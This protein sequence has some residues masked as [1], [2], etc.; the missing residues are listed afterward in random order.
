MTPRL[1]T[2]PL[3]EL[4]P[5]TSYGFDVID[6]ARDVLETPLDPW[7]EWVAVHVGELLPDGRPRFR[8]ALILVARQNGKTLLAKTLALYWMFVDQVPLVLGTSTNRD[9]ARAVWR[10][11]CDVAT[12]NPML[13][14]EL[15]PKPIWSQTGSEELI[16]GAGA[17]YKFAA[18][19]RRAGRSLT[20]HRLLLDEV[21]EHHGF[22]TWNAATNAMNAVP[23]GQTIAISNQGDNES[24]VLD[25]LRLPALEHIETGRGDARLGLFEYSA[26]PGAD[27]EDVH[28]LAQANPNLGHRIDP[29]ALLG[30]A[31][32]A[33]AAGGQEL[34]GFRTE[35]MCQR[36]HLLDPAVDPDAWETGGT[37]EPID[38]AQYR[39][40]VALCVDV[41]LDGTHASLI[42]AAVIDDKTHVEVIKAWDG[43]GCTKQL[44]ADLPD[45]VAKVKP[46][47]LG[48]F[49]AGP[50]AA[51][52]ADLADRGHRGW[53]PRRVRV[54]EIRGEV[55]QVCMGLADAVLSGEI[56]HPRDDMLTA[57][58]NAAQRLW[59]GDAWVFARK[60][61]TPIDG[62][63]AVAG[64][65][66]LARTLPPAPS[67]VTVV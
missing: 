42:A 9:Y 52:A 64:A 20:V 58:V 57:H 36:V 62:T 55:T 49:P 59:R 50:A 39:R 44:R 16:T 2:A 23:D 30:A 19:N 34:A 48:W 25:S 14:A 4:T 10:E 40:Q 41:S 27:P 17:R 28:A 35:V 11:L 29:D 13:A 18:T 46:R 8:T 22:E 24:V 47:A 7:E 60:G 65:T 6:F 5:A 26:P 3:R 63:Y 33:K 15:G 56:V 67:P 21:R 66:H 43:A 38:L 54:D 31:M 61:S 32:R 12:G 45:I 37:D 1:W 53:P 51:V